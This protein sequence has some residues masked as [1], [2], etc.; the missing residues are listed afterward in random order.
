MRLKLGKIVLRIEADENSL[1]EYLIETH[2]LSAAESMSRRH[3]EEAVAQVV[4]EL[5]ERWHSTRV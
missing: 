3:V 2:R 4:A 1:A 5:V